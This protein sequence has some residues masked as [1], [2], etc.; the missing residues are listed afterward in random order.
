MTFL[1]IDPGVIFGYAIFNDREVRPEIFG[2]YTPKRTADWLER[3]RESSVYIGKL[4]QDHRPDLCLCE[5]P[6]YRESDTGR[7]A[8]ASDSLVKLSV[9]V[10][11]IVE[12]CRRWAVDFKPIPVPVWMGNMAEHMIQR[13]VQRIMGYSLEQM[14]KSHALDAVGIGLFWKELL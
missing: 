7:A 6:A 13:R 1:S 9:M 5:W 3:C 11:M 12:Q 4:I 14:P 8:A 2:I 10:G